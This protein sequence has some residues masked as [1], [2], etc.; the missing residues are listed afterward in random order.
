[1]QTVQFNDW[2]SRL[3]NCGAVAAAAA[4]ADGDAGGDDDADRPDLGL[5]D[6]IS[7]FVMSSDICVHHLH[8]HRHHHL[9]E[10]VWFNS[11]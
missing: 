1:M 8:R 3:S 11:T 2:E 10:F 9:H 6:S 5:H 4:A 7:L